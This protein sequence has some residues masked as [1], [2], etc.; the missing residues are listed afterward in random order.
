M[1]TFPLFI[2][3]QELKPAPSFLFW[4]VD[5]TIV[6][7]KSGQYQDL[8]K[9]RGYGLPP[10]TEVAASLLKI[11]DKSTRENNGGEFMNVD[12]GKLPW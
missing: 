7:D 5:F 1:R 6:A 4:I 10:A 9:E 2:V 12:G 8:I 11:I 3:Q